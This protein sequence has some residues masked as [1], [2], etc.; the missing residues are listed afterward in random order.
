LICGLDMWWEGAGQVLEVVR[1]EVQTVEK[2]VPEE[3]Q[4]A[5]SK[6]WYL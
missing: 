5:Q 4:K 1:D 2:P 3:T 6:Q